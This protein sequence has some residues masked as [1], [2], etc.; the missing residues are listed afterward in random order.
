MQTL[1]TLYLYILANIRIIAFAANKNAKYRIFP[2]KQA[3]STVRPYF[4]PNSEHKNKKIA[5]TLAFLQI[6]H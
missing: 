3:F 2:S 5:K 6:M 1:A 4:S